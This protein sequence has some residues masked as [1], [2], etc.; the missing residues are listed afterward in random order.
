M[1]SL[2]PESG[3][4]NPTRSHHFSSSSRGPRSSGEDTPRNLGTE[5]EHSHKAGSDIVCGRCG[6]ARTRNC[7]GPHLATVWCD[8]CGA[9]IRT[10]DP[11]AEPGSYKLRF[12]R[13]KGQTLAQV[14]ATQAGRGWLVWAAAN[15]DG[16][17]GRQVRNFLELANA[18]GVAR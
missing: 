15:I 17:A 6:S 18:E 11:T 3:A 4:V 14:A 12:G 1:A 16:E 5:A 8:D 13:F 10:T 9:L 7:R 2:R